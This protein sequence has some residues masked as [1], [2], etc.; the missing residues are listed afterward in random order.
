MVHS[1]FTPRSHQ[2][3]KKV[4]FCEGSLGEMSDRTVKEKAGGIIYSKLTVYKN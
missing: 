4:P 1:F 3:H 2:S